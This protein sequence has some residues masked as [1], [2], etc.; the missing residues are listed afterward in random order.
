MF[1]CFPVS[2][3]N[4]FTG[5]MVQVLLSSFSQRGHTAKT[6]AETGNQL[7]ALCQECLSMKCLTLWVQYLQL[8]G[9][10]S[11]PF[12]PYHHHLEMLC[13]PKCAF[14]HT[15]YLFPPSVSIS[16]DLRAVWIFPFQ[17]HQLPQT[18]LSSQTY[19]GCLCWQPAL[20]RFHY[21]IWNAIVLGGNE[22]LSLACHNLENL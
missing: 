11:S 13:I 20:W 22:K 19:W 3:L 8:F 7:S 6:R 9:T 15:L 12:D 10:L 4:N 5:W 21:E 1:L 16:S 17:W 2:C 14:T 18:F